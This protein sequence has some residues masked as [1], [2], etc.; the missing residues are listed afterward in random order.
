MGVVKACR[1]VGIP[2]G[3][4]HSL[5]RRFEE[6]EVAKPAPANRARRKYTKKNYEKIRELVAQGS[7]VTNACRE[8]DVPLGSYYK[9]DHRYGKASK[10]KHTPRSAVPA[11]VMPETIVIHEPEERKR[12]KLVVIMGD[13]REVAGFLKGYLDGD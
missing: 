7:T 2:T 5:R 9:L 6:P 4:W 1:E 3:S 13:E 8:M 10:R 12:K 11:V